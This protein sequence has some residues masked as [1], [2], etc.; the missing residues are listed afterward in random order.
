[1]VILPILHII[2]IGTG[3]ETISTIQSKTVLPVSL[4][5]FS[6]CCLLLPPL[7]RSERRRLAQGHPSGFVPE[8]GLE[9]AGSGL[10]VWCLIHYAKLIRH[11]HL[12]ES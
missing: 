7:L 5:R 2:P 6:R 8:A 12:P 3:K 9:L 1:M 10:V 4:A 11:T